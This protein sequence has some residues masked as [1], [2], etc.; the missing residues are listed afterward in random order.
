MH[1]QDENLPRIR[2]DILHHDGVIKDRRA[3]LGCGESLRYLSSA[4]LRSLLLL[5]LCP[6][7]ATSFSIALRQSCG[8]GEKCGE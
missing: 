7:I 2:Q 5:L 1:C 4:L 8:E 3:V 6:A